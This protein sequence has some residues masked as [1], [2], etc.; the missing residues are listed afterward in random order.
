MKLVEAFGGKLSFRQAPD[1]YYKSSAGQYNY[2]A[3]VIENRIIY[4]K[5]KGQHTSKDIRMVHTFLHHI[6]TSL[7]SGPLYLVNDIT[8]LDAGETAFKSKFHKFHTAFNTFFDHIY[9]VFPELKSHMSAT[10]LPTNVSTKDSVQEAFLQCVRQHSLVLN[11]KETASNHELEKASHQDLIRQIKY[12]Q[13][14]N[15]QLK[16]TL[17]S[18][19]DDVYVFN[20]DHQLISSHV[21]PKKSVLV[22]NPQDHV[23][24]TYHKVFDVS[25]VEQL[26]IVLKNVIQTQMTQQFEY[27]IPDPYYALYFKV[28]INYRKDNADNYAGFTM[29]VREIT[30]EK[31]ADRKIT[32]SERKYRSVV[33]SVR[34][35]IFQTN[36]QG[37]LAFINP[38]WK[39]ISAFDIYESLDK[40]IPDFVHPA[41]KAR[42]QKLIQEIIDSKRDEVKQEIRFT[43]K[44]GKVFWVDMFF[45]AYL[46][47]NGSIAGISGTLNDITKR[48]KAEEILKQS[49]QLME[50]INKNIKEALVRVNYREGFAYFNHAFMNMFGY[51]CSQEVENL[52]L[53]AL[54][55]N[56][57]DLQ[58]YLRVL[59]KEHNFTNQTILFRRKDGSTFWGLSSFILIRDENG[60][61]FY[62]GAIRDITDH[63]EAEKKL[64]EKNQELSK[65]NQELDRFVYSAS[66]DLRAPLAST[67]GLINISRLT[68]D[69]Q[70]RTCYLELMEQ[71]LNRMDKLIQDLTDYSRNARLAIETEEINFDHMIKDI[72]QRLKYLKNIDTVAVNTRI[73]LE[74]DFHSDKIRLYIILINLLS[75]AIKYHKYDQPKPY[76]KINIT[77]NAHQAVMTV[78]DNG[79][80]IDKNHVD[81]IF[82]MFFQVSRDAVGSGLGLYIAKETVNKLEGSIKVDS[83]INEG[84]SFTVTI[85]NAKSY[86]YETED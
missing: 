58:H 31:I 68:E 32:A 38:A 46:D 57:E 17:S 53:N 35:I 79:I 72:F 11:L 41:D 23:G 16:S 84:S 34:E 66:H 60:Q 28:S 71:S 19:D 44:F 1:W 12:L 73:V 81:K 70:E 80:G 4:L 54:F 82:T 64:Q 51:Q 3:F 56:Q 30:E 18:I 67:L 50:S 6:I 24:E 25:V 69:T 37:Q 14:E 77:A 62:D 49:N 83:V 78:E 52:S 33:E 36:T 39:E 15:Q 45:K 20:K 55:A 47:E 74:S 48:K 5:E 27:C 10:W 29:V 42:V 59:L 9:L 63:K 65:T 13:E 75:N 76:I 22:D 26:D 85:P 86:R 43:D 21:N 7:P 2:E 8:Q 40:P 61:Q